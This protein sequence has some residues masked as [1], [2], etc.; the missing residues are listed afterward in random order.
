MAPEML[1]KHNYDNKSDIYGLGATFY[2]ILFGRCPYECSSIEELK[3]KIRRGKLR[4]PR[5]VND[6][7]KRV[8]DLLRRM[9]NPDPEKRIGWIELFEFDFE[10]KK[11]GV[12]GG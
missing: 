2:E 12:K 11:K 1:N 6:I 4:F 5:K 3:L 8:E 9:L 7:S 10:E